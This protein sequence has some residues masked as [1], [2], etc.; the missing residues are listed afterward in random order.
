MTAVEVP[1]PEPDW[2]EAT[3]PPYGTGKNPAHQWSVW[4]HCSPTFQM[5]GV[6]RLPVRPVAR[7]LRLHVERSWDGLDALDVVLFRLRGYSFALSKHDGSPAD[8]SYVWLTE[9]HGDADQAWDVLLE[10]VGIGAEAVAFR[11]G[12]HEGLSV[13]S[14][15]AREGTESAH[16]PGNVPERSLRA[17]IRCVI[18]MPRSPS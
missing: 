3:T 5:I 13:Q 16:I 9:P 18:G 7:R 12:A 14:S 6:L 11:G 10:V 4:E 15:T 8:V 1:E 17:R 2:Q